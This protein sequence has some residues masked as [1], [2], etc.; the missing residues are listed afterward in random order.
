MRGLVYLR[1]FDVYVNETMSFLGVVG[2]EEER[3]FWVGR[4]NI[5][6]FVVSSFDTKSISRGEG[7]TG[8]LT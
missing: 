6:H 1:Q 7:Q 3:I 8:G 4:K 2:N 5:F